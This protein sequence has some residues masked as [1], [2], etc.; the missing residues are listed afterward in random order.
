MAA[1]RIGE[2]RKLQRVLVN[3]GIVAVLN[4]VFYHVGPLIDISRN[5]CSMSYHDCNITSDLTVIVDIL[6]MGKKDVYLRQVP[7]KILATCNLTD[8]IIDGMPKSQRCCI[9]F[10]ALT[11][12]QEA[13]LSRFIES[14]TFPTA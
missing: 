1:S 6:I 12:E 9:C 14:N 8:D 3:R 13:E 5:G 2:R 4:S 10:N 11:G 7:G